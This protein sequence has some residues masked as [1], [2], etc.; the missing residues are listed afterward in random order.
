MKYLEVS[1]RSSPSQKVAVR[2]EDVIAIESDGVH[3]VVR[4]DDHCGGIRDI[5]CWESYSKLS[6]DFFGC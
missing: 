5:E 6:E 2:E 1:K 3:T 4:V